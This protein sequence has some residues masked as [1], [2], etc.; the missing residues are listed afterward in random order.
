M[1]RPQLWFQGG[2][3]I[4]SAPAAGQRLRDS[5]VGPS[6]RVYAVAFSVSPRAL[7]RLS[8]SAGVLMKGGASWMVSAP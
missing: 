7:T 6:L 4:R 1:V 8:I 3:S 2:A 5:G